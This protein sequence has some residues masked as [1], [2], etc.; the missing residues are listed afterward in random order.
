M[1]ATTR[2]LRKA[3]GVKPPRLAF[4]IA[5][6]CLGA[7][8]LVGSA[9]AEEPALFESHQLTPSG[10]YTQGIE[11]PAIDVAGALFVVN[12]ARQGTIGRSEAGRVPVGIVRDAACRQHR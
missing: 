4:A 6:S 3:A 12:F 7:L 11:G 5:L 1:I 2:R 10:E 9:S 8:G